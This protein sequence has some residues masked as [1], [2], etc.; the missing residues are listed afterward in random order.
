MIRWPRANRVVGV[1]RSGWKF[2]WDI[3]RRAPRDRFFFFFLWPFLTEIG[4]WA[5]GGAQNARKSRKKLKITQN[6]YF[7]I[8][9]CHSKFHN[10]WTMFDRFFLHYTIFMVFFIAF[11]LG[12][13]RKTRG[14][15]GKRLKIIQNMYFDI[16]LRHS[17]FHNV[18]TMFDRFFLHFTIFMEFLLLF[19][20]YFSLNIN[21]SLFFKIFLKLFQ[22]G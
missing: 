3:S 15:V 19:T 10:V 7:D 17:K 11:R 4:F 1:L 22:A 16:F 9:I 6:M 18:W 20:K 14:K 8:F 21:R 2:F 5:R 13:A 12:V